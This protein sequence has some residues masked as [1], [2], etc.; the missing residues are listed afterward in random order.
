MKNS[1]EKMPYLSDGEI[2][3]IWKYL[4]GFRLVGR[5]LLNFDDIIASGENRIFVAKFL[6][7]LKSLGINN[8]NELTFHKDIYLQYHKDNYKGLKEQKEAGVLDSIS[9]T[10]FEFLEKLLAGD[11]DSFYQNDLGIFSFI[12]YEGRLGMLEFFEFSNKILPKNKEKL[13]NFISLYIENF[14]ANN[15]KKDK[16][17]FYCF[18]K[19]RKELINDLFHKEK[20][21]GRSFIFEYPEKTA[22]SWGLDKEYL[23]IH[24]LITLEALGYFEVENIWIFDMDLSPEQQTESYKVKINLR[25]KFFDE[26]D[27]IMYGIAFKKA[28]QKNEFPKKDLTFNNQ[29]S[30]LSFNGKEI[31]I[32]KTRNSNGHY[33]LKTIFEDKNKIWEFDEIAD[34]WNDEYK[35]DDWNRYYNAGYAVNEKIAKET[36][37]KDF[38]AI[39]N[40]TVGINRKYL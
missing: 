8:L 12:F 14:I 25:D 40:K 15:L 31:E 27:E 35:K 13:E 16:E 32:S 1:Q 28:T 10:A 11:I 34:D 30:V 39:T 20:D 23:F 26:K 3:S 7:L 6:N 22:L 17:N 37:I 24:T 5:S 38:L 4:N 19:Q 29:K 9:L 33:L 18:D 2:Y 21:Y 36:T